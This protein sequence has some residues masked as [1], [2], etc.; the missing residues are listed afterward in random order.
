MSINVFLVHRHAAMDFGA[1]VMVFPGGGVDD[2]D[3][4]ADSIVGDASV[5]RNHRA[6]SAKRTD[7]DQ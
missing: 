2:R 6:P 4:N 1:G 3:R 5:A 7:P